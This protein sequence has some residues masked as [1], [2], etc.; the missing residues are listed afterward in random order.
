MKRIGILPWLLALSLTAPAFAQAP[1]AKITPSFRKPL[2]LKKLTAPA[3]QGVK[4]VK[5]SGPAPVIACNGADYDFGS[6]SQGDVVQHVFVMK[7]KGKGV[8]NIQRAR[9]G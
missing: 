9:G 7:N 5:L 6:V 2:N 4:S 8:L 1:R 3:P